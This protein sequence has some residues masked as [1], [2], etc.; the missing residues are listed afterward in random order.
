[1]RGRTLRPLCN[2]TLCVFAVLRCAVPCL[3]CTQLCRVLCSQHWALGTAPASSKTVV[4]AGP[5]LP[6]C[7]PAFPACP[8]C[9]RCSEYCEEDIDELCEEE[10]EQIQLAEGYGADSQV[11]TCLEVGGALGV[12]DVWRVSF[13]D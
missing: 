2:A 6:R 10:K 8:A 3:A 4:S 12:G 11:I 13:L 5:C 9:L 7:L 1:M